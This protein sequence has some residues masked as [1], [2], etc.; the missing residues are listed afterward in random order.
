MMERHTVS[1][2]FLITGLGAEISAHD[3]RDEVDTYI[4]T[5]LPFE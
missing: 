5:I 1:S 3:E 2:Y 4:L